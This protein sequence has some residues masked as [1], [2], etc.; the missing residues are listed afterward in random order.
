MVAKSHEDE[1]LTS[2]TN[3]KHL[4]LWKVEQHMMIV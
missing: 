4:F 1:G 3:P 2:T